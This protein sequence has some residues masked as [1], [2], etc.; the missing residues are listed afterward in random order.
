M[1]ETLCECGS[2]ICLHTFHLK[3]KS[4]KHMLEKN[5]RAVYTVFLESLYITEYRNPPITVYWQNL[6]P[7]LLLRWY[8]SSYKFYIYLPPFV[9]DTA[10]SH[11]TLLYA[12]S[13][14]LAGVNGAAD[15]LYRVCIASPPEHCQTGICASFTHI[16]CQFSFFF[17]VRIRMLGRPERSVCRWLRRS[18]V[19][20]EPAVNILPVCLMPDYRF[21]YP[22]LFK[23][24]YS[25]LPKQ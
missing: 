25:C 5:C 3:R 4:F 6:L 13:F 8:R 23:I 22:I 9:P 14:I 2:A 10:F 18:V 1:T 19:P 17:S 16:S 15:P 7:P 21:C 11:M 24:F 12:L 20:Y